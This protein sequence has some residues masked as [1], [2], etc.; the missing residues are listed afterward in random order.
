MQLQTNCI[1]GMIVAPYSVQSQQQMHLL[2]GKSI[3]I[4]L[5]PE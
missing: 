4:V 3:A 2:R 5:V 1:F